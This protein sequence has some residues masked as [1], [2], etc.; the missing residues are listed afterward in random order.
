MKQ[1]T[2]DNESDKK[3]GINGNH[4]QFMSL[5]GITCYKH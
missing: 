5:S 4:L 3:I 1:N 2:Y